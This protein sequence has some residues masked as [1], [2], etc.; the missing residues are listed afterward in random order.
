MKIMSVLVLIAV[1]TVGLA[2]GTFAYQ[3]AADAG[4]SSQA[5]GASAAAVPAAP[6]AHPAR[7][8][9]RGHQRPKVRWA[10]CKPPAVLQGKV[11][12]T[13]EVH[14]VVVPA[15]PVAAAPAAPAAPAPAP[16]ATSGGGGDHG[17]EGVEPAEY[18][19]GDQ[20]H[21]EGGGGGEHEGGG[22]GD[23]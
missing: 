10:P 7:A 17:G 8:E 23:D 21:G 20:E 6:A 11:C 19:H 5:A 15:P 1:V 22:S 4:G 9:H 16:P 14:T 12:V 13:E 3:T 2:A 18:E